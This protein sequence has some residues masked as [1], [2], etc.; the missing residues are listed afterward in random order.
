MGD[1]LRSQGIQVIV[2]E[3]CGVFSRILTDLGPSHT[4]IDKDGEELPPVMIDKMT[5]HSEPDGTRIDLLTGARHNF[6]EGSTVTLSEVIGMQS[7]GE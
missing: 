2:A 3:Q 1:L 4:V 6:E 7:L 5:A